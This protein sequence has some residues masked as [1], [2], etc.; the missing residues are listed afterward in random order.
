M[1]ADS[2]VQCSRITAR[3][4]TE[5]DLR[6]AWYAVWL[7]R[8]R[9][10]LKLHRKYWEF[11]AMAEA[12]A[13]AGCL[14]PGKRGLGFGVGREPMADL[15]ASCGCNI[16]ATDLRADDPRAHVW[17][18]QHAAGWQDLAGRR[19]CPDEERAARVAFHAVDMRDIPTDL[20][21]FDFCWS[22]SSLDHL[23]T[24]EAGV[25]FIADSLRCLAPGGIAAHTTEYNVSSNDT[26]VERG[27]TVIYRRRD[28]EGLAGRLLAPE[29]VFLPDWTTGDEPADRMIDEAPFSPDPALQ[30]PPHLKL[31]LGGH[32]V[33]S[34]LLILERA[35]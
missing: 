26:T 7:A 6:S 15:F 12:L 25:Q 2:S 29:G 10:D 11:G 1:P 5:R 24:L 4:C 22:C 27:G 33:T 9:W 30:R 18:G 13:H 8:F 34:I 23:D 19:A 16:L 21:D 17:T 20:H 14:A 32:V 3:L 35:R 28:I 31:R